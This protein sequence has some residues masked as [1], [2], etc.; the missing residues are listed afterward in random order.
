MDTKDAIQEAIEIQRRYAMLQRSRTK[1]FVVAGIS[2]GWIN[3][4]PGSMPAVAPI[5]EWNVIDRGQEREWPLE[6]QTTFDGVLFITVSDKPIWE[7]ANW[8]EL[9]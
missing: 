5:G 7:A 3:I 1:E 4:M 9:Q 8:P 2:D 6:F